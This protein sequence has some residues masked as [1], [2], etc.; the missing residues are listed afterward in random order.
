MK[1]A[2]R[3]CFIYTS[4]QIACQE[5]TGIPGNTKALYILIVY[6]TGCTQGLG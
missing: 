4:Y 3:L 6:L 5:Q 1:S 2:F